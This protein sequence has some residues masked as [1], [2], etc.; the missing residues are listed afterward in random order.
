V[1]VN[2]TGDDDVTVLAGQ[3]SE[4]TVAGG[5]ATVSVTGSVPANDS[6]V[7]NALGGADVVDASGVA[8]G[9]TALVL[10]GDDGADV[11]IGG[12]GADTINGGEGDDVLLGGPGNDLLDGGPGDNILIQ[13]ETLA[14]G[15][16][17]GEDWLDDHTE[18]VDG[19]TVLE[20]DGRSYTLP[21]ADL[22]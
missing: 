20:H 14:R 19:A 11:L 9:S 6:L 5:P 18:K 15:R 17:V 7:V 3:G 10:N 12:D 13:G 2:G 21:A 8:A 16:S 4:L 1:T 22:G